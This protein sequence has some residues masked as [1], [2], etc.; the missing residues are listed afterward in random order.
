[1]KELIGVAVLLV[2]LFGGTV[3]LRNIHD[4]VRRAALEKA[5]HG[6]PPW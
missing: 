5:A 2:S 3:V 4:A 1:M 6:L